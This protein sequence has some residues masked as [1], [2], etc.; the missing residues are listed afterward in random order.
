MIPRFRQHRIAVLGLTLAFGSF[1]TGC[2]T[3]KFVRQEVET[4]SSKLSARL[5]TNES[6]IQSN[7]NQITELIN[8]NKQTAQKIEDVRTESQQAVQKVDVKAGDAHRAAD[9]AEQTAEKATTKITGLE[10]RFINRNRYSLLSEKA[11]RFKVNEWKLNKSEYAELDQVAQTVKDNPDTVV[12]LEG[13]TDS[14]GDKEYN[15]QLGQ[16]R[17]DSVAR[18]LVVEKE[19]PAY[20]IY[21]MSYGPDKPVA[22]NHSRDGRAQNRCTVIEIL[23]PQA[24]AKDLASR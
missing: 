10:D 20:R 16:K 2:A 4:S 6:K 19:V 8:V 5:D 24:G 1:G 17:M 22:D 14:T 11:I 9:Q 21:K 15:I 23:V 3:K 12:F 18:Y 13:R 7:T